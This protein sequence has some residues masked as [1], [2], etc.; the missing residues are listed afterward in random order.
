MSKSLSELSSIRQL[1][2]SDFE[3]F[4][5]NILQLEAEAR[6]KEL[7]KDISGTQFLKQFFDLEDEYRLGFDAI[8][9]FGIDDSAFTFIEVKKTSRLISEAIILNF[10]KN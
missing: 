2:A 4:A 9:P 6:G 3:K 7:Y 10:L 1:P 5:L 8:A